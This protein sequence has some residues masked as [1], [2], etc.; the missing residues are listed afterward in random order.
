MFKTSEFA[1]NRVDQTGDYIF[2]L[3]YVL[4]LA[5]S[6]YFILATLYSYALFVQLDEV[7]F[8]GRVYFL[9]SFF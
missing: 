7:D 8:F 1:L 3:L 2:I 5:F 6:S 9:K 4:A